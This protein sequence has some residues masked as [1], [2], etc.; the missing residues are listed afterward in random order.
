[1]VVESADEHQWQLKTL[2]KI[3]EET[4]W[5]ICS[6]GEDPVFK[7]RDTLCFIKACHILRLA[8]R[9]TGSFSVD[10]MV[11]ME[12]TD[13]MALGLIKDKVHH[14]KFSQMNALYDDG[15]T[16]NWSITYEGSHFALFECGAQY[17]SLD[18]E[19]CKLMVQM[20]AEGMEICAKTPFSNSWGVFGGAGEAI[21]PLSVRANNYHIWMKKIKRAFDPNEVSDPSNYIS[22]K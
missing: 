14:D 7:S 12:S 21:K 9:P 19:A 11:G 3:L 18:P 20:R 6:L 17:G 13:A 22:G 16:N 4:C 15:N 8:A 10:G 2:Y 5:Q 1:M